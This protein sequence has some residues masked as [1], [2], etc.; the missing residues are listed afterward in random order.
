MR[1]RARVLVA[2]AV[3]GAVA[4]ATG[5]AVAATPG[6]GGAAP[7]AGR[8]AAHA[9]AARSVSAPPWSF[10]DAETVRL[11]A[12]RLNLNVEQTRTI[13]THLD[14]LAAKGGL[15]PAAPA[16]VAIAKAAD[17][18]PRGLAAA[19]DAVKRAKG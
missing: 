11:L 8:A 17:T 12:A 7:V 9:K 1:M 16:F 6:G 4:A 15:D 18:T 10:F 14:R 19:L 2:G 13:A 3:T 5:V